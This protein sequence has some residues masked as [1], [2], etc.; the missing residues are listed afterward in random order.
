MKGAS[1]GS[2]GRAPG[3]VSITVRDEERAKES[4]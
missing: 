3:Y 4:T 2:A 1:M